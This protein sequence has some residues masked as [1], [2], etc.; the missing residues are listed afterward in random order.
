MLES[1]ITPTTTKPSISPFG[2]YLSDDSGEDSTFISKGFSDIKIPR[3]IESEPATTSLLD[4][5]K[6]EISFY[7]TPVEREELFSE[8]DQTNLESEEAKATNID[9]IKLLARKYARK[10]LSKEDDARLAIVTERI[11]VL[12]PRVVTEDF[13]RLAD[14]AEEIKR[15]SDKDDELRE[16]LGLNE[17]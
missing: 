17:E 5:P 12:I 16:E 3:F 7:I 10:G 14:I 2:N 6:Q 11:R 1:F 4:Q 8:S 9:R 13:C 15:I